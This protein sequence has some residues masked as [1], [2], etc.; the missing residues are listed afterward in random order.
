MEEVVEAVREKME[1]LGGWVEG[2]RGAGAEDGVVWGWF[3]RV[4]VLRE[5]VGA[6]KV[7]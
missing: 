4:E 2:L 5:A 7:G 3:G 6:L 1:E